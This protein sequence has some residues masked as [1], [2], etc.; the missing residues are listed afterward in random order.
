MEY[1]WIGFGEIILLVKKKLKRVKNLSEKKII[2]W[3]NKKLLYA[4]SN[5]YLRINI[6]SFYVDL[7][8]SDEIY[9]NIF[10]N[11]SK[12]LII[13]KKSFRESFI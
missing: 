2:I 3:E 10:E 9:K 7:D 13:I 12:D 1:F 8:L 11:L 5:Q 6:D 4:S